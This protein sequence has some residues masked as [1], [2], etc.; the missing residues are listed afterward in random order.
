MADRDL[1]WL[2]PIG[3]PGVP[4]VPSP[5]QGGLT[6]YRSLN[7][8]I[9]GGQQPF[10]SYD[11]TEPWYMNA[12]AGAWRGLTRMFEPFQAPQDMLFSW[13]ASVAD[14][15][16]GSFTERFL[17]DQS[18]W[19]VLSAYA[20]Y[21]EAP[22]RPV[23]G[24]E[25]LATFGVKDAQALKWG[26]LGMDLLADP[27]LLGAWMKGVSA[28]ARVTGAAD[29]ANSLHRMGTFADKWTSLS[30]PYSALPKNMREAFE[31]RMFEAA[32]N[33]FNRPLPISF[34]NPGFGTEASRT[35]GDAVLG[36]RTALRL[37]MMTSPFDAVG[38]TQADDVYRLSRTTGRL[39]EQV[40]E[41]AARGASEALEA[42]GGSLMNNQERQGFLKQ[43]F[44]IMGAQTDAV[45]AMDGTPTVMR[46]FIIKGTYDMLDTH[47]LAAFDRTGQK[48]EGAFGIT[49]GP[50]GR[51]QTRAM[52]GVQSG[53][54]SFS[55]RVRNMARKHGMDPDEAWGMA[56]EFVDK[57]ATTEMMLGYHNS[58]YGFIS[59]RIRTRAID[60]YEALGMTP[61]AARRAAD[62]T[63]QDMMTMASQGGD[64]LRTPLASVAQPGGALPPAAVVSDLLDG[65]QEFSALNVN[66]FM[67]GLYQGHMRRAY[68]LMQDPGTFK[69][70]VESV[71]KGRVF[72]SHVLDDTFQNIPSGFQ[73]EFG[74]IKGLIDDLGSGGMNARQ[75]TLLSRETI[76]NHLIDKGVT[77]A[78]AQETL[79]ELIAQQNPVL[80]RPGGPLDRLKQFARDKRHELSSPPNQGV[81][82]RNFF[83]ARDVGL[84]TEDLELLGEFANPLVSLSQTASKARR[85]V[86]MTTFMRETYEGAL[87]SGYVQRQANRGNLYVDPVSNIEFSFIPDDA[88]GVWGAYAGKHIHPALKKELLAAMRDR[89][90]RQGMFERVRSIVTGGYLASPNVMMANFSGGF[91]QAA[92]LGIGPLELIPGLA[93]TFK[94]LLKHGETGEMFDSLERM[95]KYFDPETSSMM[96]RAF[97][98]GLKN[99]EISEAGLTEKGLRGFMNTILEISES[100]LKAPGM[101]R[102]RNQFLGLDGFQFVEQWFKTAAFDVEFTRLRQM[103]RNID[104]AEK[105]AA[106][107][108]RL[109]VFDYQEIPD[110]LKWV[111]N[112]GLLMFPGFNYFLL[113]RQANA[114]F[115]R[116]GVLGMQDRMAGSITD[117]FMDDDAEKYAVYGGMDDW[118]RDDGG[119]IINKWKHEDG[120][121]RYMAIPMNQLVP[122]KNLA[123]NAWGESLMAGGVYKP[124]IELL[125]AAIQGDGEAIWGQ[126]YGQRVFD[127]GASTGRKV[128]QAVDFLFS[129]LAPGWVRKAGLQE[130]LPGGYF[131]EMASGE[132]PLGAPQGLLPNIIASAFNLGQMGDSMYSI[133]EAMRRRP[134][135]GLRGEALSA[136][137]RAPQVIA[138]A[139]P[140][141]N[142]QRN[143][144]QA[145]REL[146]ETSAMDRKRFQSAMAAGNTD[147]AERIR[148]RIL[149]R[150]QEFVAEW[151]PIIAAWR[152][153][154]R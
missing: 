46:Q 141:A 63:W 19:E 4:R 12:L 87:E 96:G 64:A 50:S 52:T 127:P 3:S 114:F 154:Q 122:I 151:Q 95:S 9:L 92:G 15:A 117:F 44:K 8:P 146:S 123:G 78:R 125:T 2:E 11:D 6:S 82:G 111:R 42:V 131:G 121:M 67:R 65:L 55:Q 130:F 29:T 61:A 110:L 59:D 152:D 135:R 113:P 45:K 56:Q 10:T 91:T 81:L 106:E 22:R 62:D 68:G 145:R 34:G 58:G 90:G 107:T 80:A 79:I 149:K 115:N 112:T 148:E 35:I 105:L 16:G 27:L 14:P 69:N 119:A 128:G 48:L 73:Q 140:M 104:E 101:G 72:M 99:I 37:Q 20:P 13:A 147:T 118:M 41:A 93:R 102:F 51:A 133:N 23:S 43:F 24:E 134:D 139:G 1:S 30:G 49:L 143:Y 138:T 83:E 103:G 109:I 137:L 33:V 88:V 71:S 100:Q 97:V 86:P 70:Y 7:Q 47:G 153:G 74:L 36:N 120:T 38:R 75:G 124:F 57:I 31:T 32:Q 5:V 25:L 60:H 142:I 40:Q 66:D 85:A 28:L 108:A 17:G 89:G 76:L 94:Q 26:G 77:P 98:R 132:Q 129:S 116:P 136:T 150:Q 126:R 144:E 39:G 84:T 18:V 54:A 21:G 53:M